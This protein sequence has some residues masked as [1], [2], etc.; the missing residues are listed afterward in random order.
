MAIIC[1][2]KIEN[3]TYGKKRKNN[4]FKIA[5][6]GLSSPREPPGHTKYLQIK[7]TLEPINYRIQH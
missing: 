6:N 7:L 1:R 4:D 3:R 2:H 5:Q